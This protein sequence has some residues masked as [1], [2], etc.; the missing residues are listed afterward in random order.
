[1]YQ[2]VNGCQC[3]QECER[4]RRHAVF[5]EAVD[6]HFDIANSQNIIDAK[7]EIAPTFLE[8]KGETNLF[9]IRDYENKISDKVNQLKGAVEE[10]KIKKIELDKKKN[11]NIENINQNLK[12]MIPRFKPANNSIRTADLHSSWFVTDNDSNPSTKGADLNRYRFKYPTKQCSYPNP[13]FCGWTNV[14]RPHSN[15]STTKR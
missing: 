3:K 10:L 5:E 13:F 8:T 9:D 2:V 14:E 1:M 15:L 6:P 4:R 12:N 7:E 11:E